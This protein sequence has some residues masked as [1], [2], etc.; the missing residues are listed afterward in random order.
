MGQDTSSP[1]IKGKLEMPWAPEVLTSSRPAK[2]ER[3]QVSYLTPTG[4][5]VLPSIWGSGK[6]EVQMV[7]ER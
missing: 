7:W 2:Q 1:G 6:R 4:R 3:G 5:Q